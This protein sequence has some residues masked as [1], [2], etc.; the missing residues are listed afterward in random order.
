MFSRLLGSK[1]KDMKLPENPSKITRKTYQGQKDEE[2]RPHGHGVMEYVSSAS[3]KYKYEGHFEHGVRS[4]YGVWS[5]SVRFIK[6]YEEWE[7]VQMGEYDSAGRLIH[8][9]TKPGPYKEVVDSWNE[10]FS[11]WW[12]ND[13]AVHDFLGKKYA[14]DDFD[15]TEDAKFLS[16]FH[17][18]VAVR[19]LPMPL[20]S[21]LWNS[22]APYARYGYGVWLWASRNDE[23]SLKTA[24]QIFE[25]SAGAGIAD[26]FYMLSR[27]YYLGEA[28]DQEAGK[29]VLDRKL[30]MELLAQAIEKGSIIAKLR[31]NRTLYL[32]TPEVEAD[33]AAA[34]A[35][36]ERESSAIFNES[37]LWTERLGWLY[38]ME[39]ET[40]KA[41]NAYCMC[42]A[43]G[44]YPPIY[45]LAWIYLEAGD[46][47]YYETLMELGMKLGVPDCYVLG[48][49][50][51]PR[52]DEL[53]D[54]DKKKQHDRMKHNL[55]QG[56]NKGSGACA[57]I[58]ADA[59]LNGKYGY[60]ID[61]DKGMGYAEVAVT[62]GFNTAFNLM[63][64]AA[65]TL[66]A[67]EFM[68]EN[69][70]LKLKYDALRYG[71]DEYLDEVIKN[72]DAYVAMGY[73]D[74]IDSI[75][76]PV[77]KKKHP[78]PKTQIDPTA[79]IIQPSGVV[80]FVNDD[81]FSMSYRE[82]AQLIGAE[83]L[84]AVHFSEPLNQITKA[85]KFKGYQLAM[86][87]D[88][89]GYAKDLEDNAIGTILY[90]RGSEIRGAV[91]IALEDNRYDTHSFHFQEDLDNVISEISDMTGGLIRYV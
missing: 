81:I 33:I 29:F 1:F 39:G 34:I 40:E 58:L 88:R 32:G 55:Q 16:R 70:I 90:G 64:E 24:F 76:M 60:N 36:A 31:R 57:Y 50:Y 23:T 87:V 44:Y 49:E 13:D 73:G 26:A 71:L 67:P 80:S 59:F 69:E 72:K 82:M 3:K 18:F 28:Y 89:N 74:E 19:K 8:P 38:E 37:I 15:L 45:D 7:W 61:L 65:E 63:I 53:D 51:E 83:G 54:Y 75:W 12:R 84:D 48:C 2:G 78:A 21:K 11:G 27:M 14:E 41:V 35:E 85:C 91:I 42:I 10:K 22:T 86:Y 43:N 56:I 47:K 77:W 68:S 30:S 79:I 46:D 20:V 17:D 62:Y 66:E 6:E 5:E 4:G 9:N 52:W 25:E